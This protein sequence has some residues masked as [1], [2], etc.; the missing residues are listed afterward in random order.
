MKWQGYSP[1]AGN[2]ISKLFAK[3]TKNKGIY[4]LLM[5]AS[6]GLA[7]GAGVKWHP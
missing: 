6:L 7:L 3:L 4:Y 5:I 1:N 2:R